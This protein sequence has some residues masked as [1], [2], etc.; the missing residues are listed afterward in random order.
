MKLLILTQKIDINDPILGFFHRWVEEFSKHCE[1][2]TVI[3]LEKGEHHLPENVKVLSLGKEIDNLQPS[4]RAKLGAG[5]VPHRNEVSGAG[6]PISPDGKAIED[7]RQSRD[8][9]QTKELRKKKFSIFN[10]QLF[11]KIKYAFIFL[12]YIWQE[13]KNYDKVFVHMNQEYVFLGGLVWK[14]LNKKIMFWRNHPVGNFLTDMAVFFSD[15][16]FCTSKYSYTARFKKTEI[17][18][19]G[20]DTELFKRKAEIKKNSNSILYLGRIAPVKKLDLLIE[21]LNT[22][23]KERINFNALIVGDSLPKDLNYY[24][25][26]K[27]SV[28]KYNLSP[29][30]IFRGGITNRETIDLYNGYEALINLSPN[31]MF[32]KTIFEAMACES[33]TL[34]SNLNLKDKIDNRLIFKENNIDDLAQKIKVLFGLSVR[35]KND[36][37]KIL[38]EFVIKNH[39]IEKLIKELLK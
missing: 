2:I 1:K 5:P 11:K 33:L 37:G 24:Q 27:D 7:P 8:N 25:G 31:G 17:M 26:I 10:F 12:K 22:L 29:K 21:S 4:T 28:K 23:N 3:C 15:K 34:T 6:F 13:R 16:V 35:W 19:V 30:I 38:R 14:L 18:P 9:L 36:Y 20:I 39:S 32:D